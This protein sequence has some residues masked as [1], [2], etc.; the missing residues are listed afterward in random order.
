[1]RPTSPILRLLGG[2]FLFLV[3]ACSGTSEP[4][5]EAIDR[6]VFIAAYVDL[7][8]AA[9]SSEG[10]TITQAQREGILD[11][12]GVTEGDLLSFAEVHG[13]DVPFMRGVWNEVEARL[14]AARALPDT[15]P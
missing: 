3:A 14:D 6:E 7:R 12:H 4:S 11:R 13:P 1:M 2:G 8:V 15:L 5:P 10:D 9:F